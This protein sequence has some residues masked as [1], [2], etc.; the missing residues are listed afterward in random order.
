MQRMKTT[1]NVSE[2]NVW[3]QKGCGLGYINIILY[4]PRLKKSLRQEKSRL[5]HYLVNGKKKPAM[6]KGTVSGSFVCEV[7]K[8]VVVSLY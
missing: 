6:C 1:T 2:S 3:K 7:R 5:M 8:G 4:T